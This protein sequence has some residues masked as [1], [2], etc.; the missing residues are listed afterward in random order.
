MLQW[1]YCNTV[2]VGVL[3]KTIVQ[4]TNI[5]ISSNVAAVQVIASE[6]VVQKINSSNYGKESCANSPSLMGEL[7]SS[8]GGDN[9]QS[10]AS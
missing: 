3:K 9:G 8:G 6:T 5:S 4:I 7:Q 1:Q 2:A 10:Q